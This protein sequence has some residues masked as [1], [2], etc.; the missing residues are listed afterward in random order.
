[1]SRRGS[2]RIGRPAVMPTGPY[3]PPAAVD[4]EHEGL[5][6][7][8]HGEDGR[9]GTFRVS[10]LP[11]PGWHEP[12]AAAWAVHIGPTGRLRTLAS[13][14]HA[15]GVV[16]RLLRFLDSL[17][18]PPADPSGLTAEHLEGF[19]R[20]R[21]ATTS[22]A[23]AAREVRDLGNL[24]RLAPLN[25]MV[26]PAA[27]EY[28][29]R[30]W[31]SNWLVSKP[32]Y[33]PRELARLITIARRD[34][35]RI[36]DRIQA[37]EQLLARHHADP[38]NLS[39][40]EKAEAEL[41]ASIAE[42]GVVPADPRP[43][44][45]ALPARTQIA[46]RLFLTMPDLTPLLV[47]LVV[48]TG[49]N[50]ETIKELPAEHRILEGW[51]VELR[52]RKRRR[53]AKHWTDTVTWEI[54]PAGRELHTPGGLYLLLHRLC[55][56]S[57]GFSG[58]DRVWSSWRSGHRAGVEGVEEHYD[59]FGRSLHGYSTYPRQ[60]VAKHDLRGESGTEDSEP[61]R[62][63]LDF[64]RL[65]TSI[66]VRRTR[67]LGGHLPSVAR[68]NTVPVLFSNYLRGD[69]TTIEWA[70]QIVSEAVVDAEQAALAAHRAAQRAAG[71]GPRI[72]TSKESR[73]DR[74]ED[75]GGDTAWARCTNPQQHPTTGSSCRS[76]FLDCF[77][78]GNCLI[79]TAHLPRL[80]A[81][82]DAFAQRR[83]EMPEHDWWSRYGPTWAAIRH[84]VLS[85]FS[86]AELER[87]TA[88]KPLEALLDLVE[89]PWE[90]P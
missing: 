32:G 4:R 19:F 24:V 48:L 10:E 35:V 71:G 26:P 15:W 46:G 7:G 22:E 68:S 65:K 81:L 73:A 18:V 43:M 3:E 53:G 30:R 80:L 28:V 90:H 63:C 33:S 31:D 61:P 57:R 38:N 62:F 1:M 23:Y 87:A 44:H 86:P 27:R 16:G 8:F 70:H 85:K 77:R 54:G 25:A 79:T 75:A 14:R 67:Q 39:L 47:L 36:R 89:D 49:R 40:A 51:A 60:W 82:L 66:D 13:V 34:V 5:S 37:G 64:N 20:H 52:L 88:D 45:L 55:A 83:Q 6:V 72:L 84:D 74:G 58:S 11:L 76:S 41:L 9:R 21:V 59:P 56:R 2:T 50:I 42:T 12:L 17:P 29:N 69:A 78:C